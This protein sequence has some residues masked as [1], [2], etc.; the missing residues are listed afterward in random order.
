MPE[1]IAYLQNKMQSSGEEW[2]NLDVK[3]SK[4]GKPYLDIDTWKPKKGGGQSN[5][6]TYEGDGGFDTFSKQHHGENIPF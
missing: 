1:L 2:L 3:I 5:S 4:F 6:G